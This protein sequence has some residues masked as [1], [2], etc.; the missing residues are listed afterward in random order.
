MKLCVK[1][2]KIFDVQDYFNVTSGRRPG[3]RSMGR[4]KPYLVRSNLEAVHGIY[5][6][7]GSKYKFPIWINV[8]TASL[9]ER[10]VSS[11]FSNAYYLYITDKSEVVDFLGVC[12]I[13]PAKDLVFSLKYRKI[14]FYLKHLN[15]AALSKVI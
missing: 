14:A 6:K 10:S 1:K 5:K 11:S 15:I 8:A 7:L 3:S 2:V 4:L 12:F 13:T 9:Y